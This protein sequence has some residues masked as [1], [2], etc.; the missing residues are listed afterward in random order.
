[1]CLD[2][3]S[4]E[5]FI[6]EPITAWKV[7]RSES[8]GFLTPYMPARFTKFNVWCNAEYGEINKGTSRKPHYICTTDFTGRE[9]IAG[10]HAFPD[11]EDAYKFLRYIEYVFHNINQPEAKFVV[12]KILLK[13]NI[14]YGMDNHLDAVVGT[15]MMLVGDQIEK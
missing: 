4:S 8:W 1:M 5:E 13:G 14:T 9:Y 11:E 6:T 7:F 2:T 10:F 12:I 15:E 3:F